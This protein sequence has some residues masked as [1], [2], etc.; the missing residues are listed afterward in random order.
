MSK[1]KPLKWKIKPYHTPVKGGL[2]N[3]LWGY[4]PGQF[5]EFIFLG[6][7][8]VPSLKIN[9]CLEKPHY[10]CTPDELLNNQI[11]LCIDWMF[12]NIFLKIELL[13]YNSL[14]VLLRIF[15]GML[16]KCSIDTT[17]L[18]QLHGAIA[19]AL[20]E[21]YWENRVKDLPF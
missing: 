16:M 14:G 4:A 19:S 5:T 10:W 17:F 1:N 8:G 21:L 20:W 6:R 2:N 11:Q 18:Q 13:N 12:H 3:Q 7:Y 15:T 9:L